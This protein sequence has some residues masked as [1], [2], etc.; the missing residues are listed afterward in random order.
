MPIH[1]KPP[2]SP[3]EQKEEPI[4]YISPG[5]F[6]RL[7]FEPTKVL[8]DSQYETSQ[9][10]S[11]VTTGITWNANYKMKLRWTYKQHWAEMK[12]CSTRYFNRGLILGIA[13]TS[14]V[15]I[16]YLTI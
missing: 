4:P 12:E 5:Y 13:L 2:I 14:L 10:D 15:F 7:K 11:K 9:P 3:Q 8:V 16:T 6:G 1:V